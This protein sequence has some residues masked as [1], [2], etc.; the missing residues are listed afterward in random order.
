M[1]KIIYV[2][3]K[4]LDGVSRDTHF[5]HTRI[6]FYLKEE[7]RILPITLHTLNVE[8]KEESTNALE[9]S[10]PEKETEIIKDESFIAIFIKAIER[11]KVYLDENVR[12]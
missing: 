4:V 3:T 10:L 6:I 1:S 5:Y 12:K 11:I 9:I 7:E 8:G 2:L